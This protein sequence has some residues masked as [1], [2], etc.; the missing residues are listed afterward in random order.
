MDRDLKLG[1]ANN[2]TWSFFADIYADLE[3]RFN[4][5]LFEYEAWSLPVLRERTERIRLSRNLQT[6]LRANDVVFFEWASD[7]LATASQFPK[8]CGIVTRLHRYELYQWADRVNWDAVDR[9]ILVSRAKEREFVA[10]FPT[11]AGKTVVSAPSTRLDRFSCHPRDYAGTIGILCHLTPRKR[12]YELILAFHE[13]I[14]QRADFHLHIGGGPD[15]A[16]LDYYEAIRY[17][18]KELGLERS[19]TFDGHV[20]DAPAWFQNIDI[21]VSNSY[22]EGLQVAPMEAMASGCFCLS[23]RW[24]GAE[25]LVPEENLFFLNTELIEKILHFSNLPQEQRVTS[26]ALMR[27]IAVQKFD[28]ENTKAQIAQT[29][30]DARAVYLSDLAGD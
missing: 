7:L 15:P 29:I 8:T 21:F 24:S 30:V 9:I 17:L 11:C 10:R 18:V 12:V 20:T 28:I 6:F 27:E 2:E 16:F 19:V 5:S 13:L 3:A 25:E 22:S 14:Q 1:V 23:H 4:T 26:R